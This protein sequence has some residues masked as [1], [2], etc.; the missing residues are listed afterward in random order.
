MLY[1]LF[2]LVN[3]VESFALI[4]WFRVSSTYES[5]LAAT[6]CLSIKQL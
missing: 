6:S 1:C 2:V 5:W 3:E 4:T